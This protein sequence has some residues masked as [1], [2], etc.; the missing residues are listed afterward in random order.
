MGEPKVALLRRMDS[1]PRNFQMPHF[2]RVTRALAFMSGGALPLGAAACGMATYEVLPEPA[3]C[4]AACSDGALADGPSLSYDGRAV[5]LL[6]APD[7]GPYG[8]DG[9]AIGVSPAPDAADDAEAAA[10]AADAASDATPPD[11]SDSGHLII[12]GPLM[13]PELPS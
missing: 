9:Q 5:G 1:K 7:S 3:N 4:D 8:Y 11:S 12:G 2:L 6:P 13:P 10:D